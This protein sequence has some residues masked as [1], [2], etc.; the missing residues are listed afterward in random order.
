MLDFDL[1]NPEEVEYNN[2]IAFDIAEKELGIP[3]EMNGAEMANCDVPDR[4]T[5]TSYLT[6]IYELL[7]VSRHEQDVLSCVP[8]LGRRTHLTLGG[9][10]LVLK[11]K[12]MHK[13]GTVVTRLQTSHVARFRTNPPLRVGGQ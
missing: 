1:L 2:Q 6:K 8:G 4:L 3:P 11:G 12:Q 9:T 10:K 13:V 5:L 7:K